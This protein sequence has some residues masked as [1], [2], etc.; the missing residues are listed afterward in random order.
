MLELRHI[1][2][3]YPTRPETVV[4]RDF[5]LVIR[6]GECC[7]LVGASGGG[8]SS[9]VKLLQRLY[10]PEA[11]AITLGGVPLAEFDNEW[12]H[13]CMA[14]VAQEREWCGGGGW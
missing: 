4:L 11:G 7:A 1:T 14:T 5:S 3:R 10:D 8:K 9:V 13:S 12:L 6:P 2:F